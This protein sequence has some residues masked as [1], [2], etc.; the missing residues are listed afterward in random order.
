[1]DSGLLI[2]QCRLLYSARFILNQLVFSKENANVW[3]SKA[4]EMNVAFNH[5][6]S[7][8]PQTRDSNT[9]LGQGRYS[10]VNT[11]LRLHPKSQLYHSTSL[12]ASC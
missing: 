12:Q 11:A 5:R 4:F 2:P 9:V 3:V 8:P 7:E 6:N 1:M 10:S